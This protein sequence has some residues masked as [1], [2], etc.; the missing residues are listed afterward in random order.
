[1]EFALEWNDL[2]CARGAEGCG[3]R[4]TKAARRAWAADSSVQGAAAYKARS[5]RRPEL[6]DLEAAGAPGCKAAGGRGGGGAGARFCTPAAAAPQH[7]ST[8]KVRDVAPDSTVPGTGLPARSLL[9]A[10][11]HG[12]QGRGESVRG[13]MTAWAAGQPRCRPPG[14][15]CSAQHS[16]S[17]GR[18]GRQAGWLAGRSLP[19]VGRAAQRTGDARADDACVNERLEALGGGRLELAGP[20][21]EL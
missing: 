7:D 15:A 12:H 5:C 8:R 20:V 6:P 11:L 21:H 1:M 3:R 9:L 14:A 10:R 19:V 17:L 18:P 4:G 16:A 2:P 13:A